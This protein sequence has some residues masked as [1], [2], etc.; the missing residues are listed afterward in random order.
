MPVVPRAL[1]AWRRRAVHDAGGFA[2]E[3]MA[4]DADLT[5]RLCRR[6]WRVVHAASARARTSGAVT[7]ATDESRRSH[8]QFGALQALW[9]HRRALLETSS[10]K[11]GSVVWPLTLLSRVVMPMLALAAGIGLVLA[12]LCGSLQ[13]ILPMLLVVLAA[14]LAQLVLATELARTSGGF[15]PWTLARSWLSALLLYR[16]FLLL[17]A[18]RS[19]ARAIEGAPIETRG[20]A[21]DKTLL[22]YGAMRRALETRQ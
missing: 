2:S 1:G 22:A 7:W 10:G 4:P 8:D 19:I 15:G 20:P 13:P 9:R 3:T 12:A 18:W 5:M 14:E 6:R 16:P 21:R 11:L 17:V